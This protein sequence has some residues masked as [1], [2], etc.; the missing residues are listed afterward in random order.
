MI[1]DEEADMC[2]EK[3][4]QIVRAWSVDRHDTRYNLTEEHLGYQTLLER[5]FGEYKRRYTQQQQLIDSGAFTAR[6]ASAMRKLAAVKRLEI[7]DDVWDDTRATGVT[8]FRDLIFSNERLCKSLYE[9]RGLSC[10]A[11]FEWT[12]A[13]TAVIGQSEQ[14]PTSDV[15]PVVPELL[16]A[17]GTAGVSIATLSID[18]SMIPDFSRLRSTTDTGPKIASAVREL[19]G[20]SFWLG[21][22]SIHHGHHEFKAMRDFIAPII[23]AEKLEEL[24]LSLNLWDQDSAID[25]AS[26]P[27]VGI[28]ES[29][30]SRSDLSS[31]TLQGLPIRFSDLAHLLKSVRLSEGFVSMIGVHLMDGSWAEILEIL[32]DRHRWA[33][34]RS[35]SGAECEEL[36]LDAYEKIF[37]SY[38]DMGEVEEELEAEQYIGRQLPANPLVHDSS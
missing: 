6:V 17:L 15:V 31:V 30:T 38:Y 7:R 13:L 26:M 20:F 10:R 29:R 2:V 19:K 33:F 4:E 14:L 32:R 16:A 35:P 22:L 12:D 34:L 5:A 3:I 23:N 21:D 27:V 25:P 36:S 11:Q 8:S 9:D 28:I 24:T 37:G 18:L 1:S